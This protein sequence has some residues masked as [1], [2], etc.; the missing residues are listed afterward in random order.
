MEG[1]L[2]LA[3]AGVRFSGVGGRRMA[4]VLQPGA[5]LALHWQARLEDHIGSFKAEPLYARAALMAERGALTAL[6]A[7]CALL[8]LALPERDPHPELYART[9]ALLNLL[10]GGGDWPM[11]YLSWEMRLL[12]EMG[13]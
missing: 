13:Y 2:A 6:N 1:L 3:P 4:G 12:D 8:H 10:E 5:H 11:A 7:I 9:V